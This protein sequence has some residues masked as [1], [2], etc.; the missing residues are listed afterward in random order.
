M[1]GVM[2]ARIPRT[3]LIIH[4]GIMDISSK[5]TEFIRILDVGEKPCNLALLRQW[6]E[7]LQGLL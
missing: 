6:F 1:L 5:A 4:D 3:N 2:G 7:L